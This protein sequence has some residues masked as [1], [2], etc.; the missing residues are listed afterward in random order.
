M[1][2]LMRYTMLFVAVAFSQSAVTNLRL[3]Q[4]QEDRPLCADAAGSGRAHA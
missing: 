1:K 3:A 2:T 4:A